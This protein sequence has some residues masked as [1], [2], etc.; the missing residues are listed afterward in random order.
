MK[1]YFLAAVLSEFVQSLKL[2]SVDYQNIYIFSADI[3][4]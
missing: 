4:S 2:S 1:V 3:N